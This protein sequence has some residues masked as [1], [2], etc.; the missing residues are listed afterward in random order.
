MNLSGDDSKGRKGWA[1]AYPD[2]PGWRSVDL[3]ADTQPTPASR[4]KSAWSRALHFLGELLQTVVMAGLL[5]LAV[6]FV[7]AR[8]RIESVSMLPSLQEGE[9]VVI[10]RMAYVFGEP[11]RGDIVVFRFPLDP[12]RRYI[13]RVIGLPGDT[14]DAQDGQIIVNGEPLQEPYIA[15]PPQY[16]GEWVVGEGE[17]FVLGDN[18]NNSLDSKNWGNLPVDNVIG[19]ATLVYWPPGEIG[20]IPHYQVL[21]A[22]SP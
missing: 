6:N 20:L 16:T 15:S 11:E 2:E 13:K 12:N 5:F 10:N 3:M 18:R 9:F 19:K 8:I 21:A 14:V 7:T 1:E 22:E 4:P 17:L